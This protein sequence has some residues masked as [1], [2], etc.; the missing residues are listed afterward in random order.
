MHL[1][2]AVAV[3]IQISIHPHCNLI[4]YFIYIHIHLYLYILSISPLCCSH[5]GGRGVD[6]EC[7]CTAPPGPRTPADNSGDSHK[8]IDISHVK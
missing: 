7:G 2:V 4:M 3:S 5:A 1:P 6:T 8:Y